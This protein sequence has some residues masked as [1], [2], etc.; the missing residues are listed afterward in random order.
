MLQSPR[1]V[2]KVAPLPLLCHHLKAGGNRTMK[3]I[4]G[5]GGRR[6][7]N[8]IHDVCMC[9]VHSPLKF[10]GATRPTHLMM[11]RSATRAAGQQGSFQIHPCNAYSSRKS[12]ALAS[13]LQPITV[14]RAHGSTTVLVMQIPRYRKQTPAGQITPSLTC[15]SQ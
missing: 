12:F 14:R 11:G 5:S 2:V 1:A 9:D 10:G 3:R 4:R 8:D 13:T 6:R 7:L 15:T